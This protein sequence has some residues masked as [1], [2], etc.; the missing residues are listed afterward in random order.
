MDVDIAL[1]ME[2]VIEI[3]EDFFPSSCKFLQLF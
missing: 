3:V 1:L 2:P